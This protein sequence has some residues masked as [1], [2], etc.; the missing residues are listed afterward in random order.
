MLIKMQPG[1]AAANQPDWFPWGIP[2][3]QRIL[4]SVLQIEGGGKKKLT[5]AEDAASDFLRELLQPF[6]AMQQQPQ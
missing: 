3:V 4:D 5:P 1:G 2:P 6:M